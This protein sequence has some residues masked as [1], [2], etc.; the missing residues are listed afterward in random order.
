M[1]TSERLHFINSTVFILTENLESI[2]INIKR[3][4]SDSGKTL[5]LFKFKENRKHFFNLLLSYIELGTGSEILNAQLDEMAFQHCKAQIDNSDYGYLCG[6]LVQE[7]ETASGKYPGI[8]LN[9]LKISWTML[10]VSLS[11]QIISYSQNYQ[12]NK[13][14]HAIKR[15]K[16][17]RRTV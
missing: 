14:T 15:E 10:V 17:T 12:L 4:I 5:N 8:D 7:L 3:K 2:S 1:I 11:N 16:H 9:E 6:Y 13:S